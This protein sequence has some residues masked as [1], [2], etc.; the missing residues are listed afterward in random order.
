[1]VLMNT[2]FPETA[3]LNLDRP[4]ANKHKYNIGPMHNK[5]RDLLDDFYRPHTDRLAKILKDDR[6]LWKENTDH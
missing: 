5:T 4:P 3:V 2:Y 1:M 6:F